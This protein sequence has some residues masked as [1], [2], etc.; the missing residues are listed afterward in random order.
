MEKAYFGGG[1]FWGIENQFRQLKGVVK[2]RSGYMGDLAKSFDSEDNYS[3]SASYVEVVE[4]IYDENT[5]T[6]EKLVKYFFSFHD[7][8]T[9]NK[10]GMD[11]GSQ[12]RSAIFFIDERQKKVASDIIEMLNNSSVFKR[13]IVT[14]LE[15]IREFVEAEEYHQNYFSK[16]GVKM[17][18]KPLKY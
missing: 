7:P 4:L 18:I 8:T 10:Q 17:V 5:I 12:Y 15:K 1:C 14:T 2:V 11:I 6:Y 13:E 3:D 16:I 9:L